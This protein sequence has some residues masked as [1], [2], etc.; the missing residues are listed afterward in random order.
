MKTKVSRRGDRAVTP[1]L[2][3]MMIKLSRAL[4]AS[5]RMLVRPPLMAWTQPS[6]LTVAT[7]LSRLDQVMVADATGL[8]WTSWATARANSDSPTYTRPLS[9]NTS[10]DVTRWLASVG[11]WHTVASNDSTSTPAIRILKPTGAE[12]D[13][14]SGTRLNR[15]VKK[16]VGL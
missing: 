11:P 14:M 13:F 5:A 8:P 2:S 10:T 6:G 3:T 1:R 4:P 16:Q 7:L 15:L 12:S 9:R